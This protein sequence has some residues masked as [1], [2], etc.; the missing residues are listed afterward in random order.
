MRENEEQRAALQEQAVPLEERLADIDRRIL[1]RMQA[2]ERLAEQWASLEESQKG[3]AVRSVIRK[4]VLRWQVVPSGKV[5]RYRLLQ[6]ETR[7]EFASDE[8][9]VHLDR[10]SLSGGG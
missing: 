6:D 2:M 8:D 3:E 10:R 9:S 4:A 7:W 1:E 5:N